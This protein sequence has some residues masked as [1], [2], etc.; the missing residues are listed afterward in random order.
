MSEDKERY[1]NRL[2]YA[3]GTSAESALNALHPGAHGIEYQMHDG[4]PCEWF[5]TYWSGDGTS[6][7]A[8]G[9]Y[10]RGGVI[11]KWWK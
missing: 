11:V 9:E 2:I 6:M 7:K 8:S 10:V 1:Q 5:V 4:P 3:V